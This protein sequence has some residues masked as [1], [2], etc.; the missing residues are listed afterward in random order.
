MERGIYS[1]VDV[2]CSNIFVGIVPVLMKERIMY[3]FEVNYV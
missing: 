1:A 2:F 3:T